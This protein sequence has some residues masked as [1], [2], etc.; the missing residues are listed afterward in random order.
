MC[1]VATQLLHDGATTN[2][3]TST[4]Q[5]LK[6]LKV[7]IQSELA[8]SNGQLMIALHPEQVSMDNGK[9]SISKYPHLER[10]IGDLQEATIF[11]VGLDAFQID[12]FQEKEQAYTFQYK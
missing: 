6:M 7:T 4:Q 2:R 3:A 5:G 1:I 8:I 12:N 9:A 10:Y 11:Y